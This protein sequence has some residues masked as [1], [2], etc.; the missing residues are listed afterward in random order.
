LTTTR[1]PEGV[2]RANL[3][4]HDFRGAKA[5]QKVEGRAALGLLYIIGF[6]I[7]PE[8]LRELYKSYY[9]NAAIRGRFLSG[10]SAPMPFGLPFFNF[11]RIGSRGK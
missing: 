1:R 6:Y 11:Q 4:Q 9:V 5:N 10:R 8:G 3:A 7:D 2:Q